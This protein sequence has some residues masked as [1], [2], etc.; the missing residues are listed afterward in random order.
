MKLSRKNRIFIFHKKSQLSLDIEGSEY[1]KID[2]DF[3]KSW[4]EHHGVKSK[5]FFEELPQEIEDSDTENKDITSLKK[6]LYMETKSLIFG[7]SQAASSLGRMLSSNRIP[8]VGYNVNRI[9]DEVFLNDNLRKAISVTDKIYISGGGNHQASGSGDAAALIVQTIREQL[10]DEA[11]IVWI[12]SIPP[13][14]DGNAKGF[15]LLGPGIKLYNKTVKGRE[16]RALEINSAIS[17]FPNVYVVNPFDFIRSN[18][19]SGY[20]CGGA[21]DGIHAPAKVAQV[22]AQKAKSLGV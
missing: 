12:T 13:A 10:N 17:G 20:Y 16:R 4:E 15:S 21:C 7:D 3:S 11:P 14:F 2:K 1:N 19:K 6:D 5:N 22:I 18:G 8:F 9:K